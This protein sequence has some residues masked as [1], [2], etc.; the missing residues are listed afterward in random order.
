[1][2]LQ[3]QQGPRTQ[4]LSTQAWRLCLWVAQKFWEPQGAR[5]VTSILQ[6]PE[7]RVTTWNRR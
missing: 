6:S 3:M 2:K 7:R 5:G 4:V 1:M